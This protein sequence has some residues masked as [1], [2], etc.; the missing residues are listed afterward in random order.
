MR[1]RTEALIEV[2]DV[3]RRF[4]PKPDLAAK[5]AL[6]LGLARPA[7]VVHALDRVS[8]HVRQGEVMGLVGESGCGKSTL[9][10]IIAGII[11]PTEGEVRWRGTPR[12]TLPEIGRSAWWARMGTSGGIAV[13]GGVIKK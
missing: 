10:R 1:T 4:G 7:P 3:T 6:R 9:G 13:G 8:L 5:L 2:R 11:P 12:N